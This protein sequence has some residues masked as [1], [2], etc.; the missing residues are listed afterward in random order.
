MIIPAGMS[1]VAGSCT[2]KV[3]RSSL[4]VSTLLVSVSLK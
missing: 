3:M 2:V 1:G 4:G